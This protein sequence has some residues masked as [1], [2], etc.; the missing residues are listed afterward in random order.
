MSAD[1]HKIDKTKENIRVEKLDADTRK[2]LFERF[3]DA[4]GKVVSDREKNRNLVIDREKQQQYRERMDNLKKTSSVQGKQ[5]DV[6]TQKPK[7][8]MPTAVVDDFFQK[9]FNRFRLR[10]MLKFKRIT[11]FNGYYFNKYFIKKFYS[12]HRL[13]MIEIQLLFLDIFKQ[14]LVAGKRTME[15]LDAMKPLYF[16]LIE[17][18]AQI[19]DDKKTD[20]IFQNY[21]NFPNTLQKVSALKEPILDLYK[22]LHVLKM[23]ENTIYNAYEKALEIQTIILGKNALPLSSNKKKLRKNLYDLFFKLYPKLH[24]LFCF[25]IGRKMNELD[26]EIDSIL[27]IEQ[28]DLPGNRITK[29]VENTD[30]AQTEEEKEIKIEEKTDEQ[31]SI[32][33][34]ETDE[35]KQGLR[36]MYKLNLLKIRYDY[37]KAGEYKIL[38]DNDKALITFLLFDEFEREYS[39]ILTT[40]KIQFNVTFGTDGRSNFSDRLSRI[41]DE[42]RKPLEYIKTYVQCAEEYEKTLIEHHGGNQQYIEYMK[43]ADSLKKKKIETS[44]IARMSVKAFMDRIASE[45]KILIDDMNSEQLYIINPQDELKFD[46]HIEGHKKIHNKKIYEAFFIVYSYARALSYRLG[47]A[48]DLAGSGEFDDSDQQ[49][50]IVE[51]KQSEEEKKPIADEEM[52]QKTGPIVSTNEEKKSDPGKEEQKTLMDELNDFL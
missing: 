42:I 25:Y 13:S 4:G 21:L 50:A 12:S 18:T 14:D 47:P 37:D 45:L 33:K 2:E 28:T 51:Q 35:I 38:E 16:E 41:Y 19:Y 26:P 15:R 17:L 24:L 36:E 34:N 49:E 44:R 40:N 22:K 29:K 20:E 11:Q 6:N 52:Q 23:Y 46:S 9:F 30:T 31:K 43:R 27:N 7:D 5:H 39:F 3:V 48:G 32:E 8:P 1:K 10:L